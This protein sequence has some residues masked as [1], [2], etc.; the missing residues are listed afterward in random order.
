MN[1]RNFVFLFGSLAWVASVPAFAA[2]T[3][4]DL[5]SP[6]ARR[7]VVEL[8]TGLAQVGKPVP[9]PDG[10]KTPFNPPGFDRPD[11]EEQKAL[12]A[13]LT[14]IQ[15]SGPKMYTPRE[16]LEAVAPR[17][18]PSGTVDM[19]GKQMLSYGKKYYKVGDKFTITY[20]GTDY[21]VTL[22]AIGK[23]DFKLSYRNEEI[24]RP[25]KSGKP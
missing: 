6:E 8:A 5:A 24:T 14:A 15:G 9:V 22:T 18:Q 10:I 23:I 19:K 20:E 7:S 3:K 25:I 12:S 1:P 13:T 21:E 16:I 2:A 11:A 17:I 4:S